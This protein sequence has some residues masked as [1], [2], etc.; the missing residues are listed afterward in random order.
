MVATYKYN[1]NYA[2]NIQILNMLLRINFQQTCHNNFRV[3][4]LLNFYVTVTLCSL[5][6]NKEMPHIIGQ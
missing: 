5:L 4:V 3:E 2:I 6:Q 1:Y